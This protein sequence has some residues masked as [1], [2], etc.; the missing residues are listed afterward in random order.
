MLLV[1]T[2]VVSII[3][4]TMANLFHEDKSAYIHDLTAEMAMHTAAE[5]QSLLVGYY[6]RLQVF[7]LLMCK[8]DLPQE[9]KARLFNQLFSRFPEFV[10]ITLYE[11][12]RQPIT[13]Y[14]SKTLEDAGL[15]KDAF[16][17]Y[18]RKHPI[19][20][21]LIQS[22]EPFVENATLSQKL[23]VLT[24]AIAFQAPE[25]D[26]EV[27]V[28]AVI[29]LHSLLRLVKRSKIFTCFVVDYNG[30]PLAH[31][32]MQM[33]ID[34]TPVKW[35]PDVQSLEGKQSHGTTL[36]FVQDDVAMIGGLAGI[37][38]SKLI[39]GVQIP[40][41][42]AYLTSKQLLNSLVLVALAL[43]V[44]SAALSL[45][46]SHRLTRPLENLSKATKVVG[47]GQFDVQIPASTKDEFG[48]L[49][50]SFNQMASELS[51]RDNEL[52]SAQEALVQSEK[53]AAFGQLGAG[54]AHEVKN[55]LAGILGLTQLCLLEAEKATTQFDNLALIEKETKR[56]K[57]IIENLLKF[58][59]QEKVAF[60]R[61]EI[62]RVVEDAIAIVNHQMGIHQVKLHK[63]LAPD[64]PLVWGNAN[65]IQQVFL[66][67]M[68]NAQ[69]AMDGNPG[70]VSLTTA[71][72]DSVNVQIQIIDN[73]PGIAEEHQAKIF[74]PFY[75]TKTSDKGTGLGL[76]VSY[77]IVKEHKGDILISSKSGEG[78]TFTIILPVADPEDRTD[79][80]AEQ[81]TPQVIDASK[82]ENKE[83]G[84]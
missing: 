81:A 62:N 58:S 30:S 5:A 67:L 35:I 47:K 80:A 32:D 3:T 52:K 79:G 11:I 63:K 9:Q 33:V 57:T 76:S 41:N 54:I 59:R 12:N 6:E 71:C 69:Q 8:R 39:T 64:L 45:I 50:G 44:V 78:T 15:T 48:Q 37:D 34:R 43:L 55:P 61:I 26:R 74:E 75:T 38:F 18:R 4:F 1:I 60:D 51:H 42:K 66:N 83:N 7:A 73:G 36:E 17:S 65:Q 23:P 82:V 13:V 31:S 84:V 40:T 21:A 10:A 56:C 22:G 25:M 28:A 53:M 24:M 77:G 68:I 72:L 20:L 27:V 29:H 49:A 46:W 70:K 14:D 16:L 19:P 2:V